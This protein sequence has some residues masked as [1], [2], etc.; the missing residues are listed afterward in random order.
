MQFIIVSFLALSCLPVY[1][2][3]LSVVFFS[4]LLSLLSGLRGVTAGVDYLNYLEIYRA[5]SLGG[6]EVGFDFLIRLHNAVFSD[7]DN[8]IFITAFLSIFLK[9]LVLYRTKINVGFSLFLYFT[10]LYPYLEFGF[11]RQSLSLAF[12]ML[13][14][15]F[16][17]FRQRR[18]LGLLFFVLSASFHASAFFM[19]FVFL[20]K[21]R[22]FIF[23]KHCTLIIVV[24]AW[25]FSIFGLMS[26]ILEM[27]LGANLISEFLPFISWKLNFYF[28][29]PAYSADPLNPYVMRFFF[30]FM[31]LVYFYERL[32]PVRPLMIA[33][34]ISVALIL[35]FSFN[36][37]MY[38][39]I[40]VF[41]SFFEILLV[42]FLVRGFHR[43]SRILAYAFFA[44]FYFL[45]M[46]KSAV[47][48]DVFKVSLF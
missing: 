22:S 10:V 16:L 32:S 39:R 34:S 33:Y 26:G 44:P 30:I 36:V 21:G 18:L 11:I 14:V 23:S 46:V 31:V 48:F 28:F 29:N 25:G 42:S 47:L 38:T 12:F 45:F 19:I 3:F 2:G 15:F 13:S 37:Q 41:A 27:F 4:V 9:V 43:D 8:F 5:N 40:G 20:I 24:V 1:L 35:L 6:I 17:V 7:F